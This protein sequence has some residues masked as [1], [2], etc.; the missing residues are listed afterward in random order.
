MESISETL[1]SLP[2][3]DKIKMIPGWD[4]FNKPVFGKASN[5]LPIILAVLFIIK[6]IVCFA[7]CSASGSRWL[8]EQ[9]NYS[10]I[11]IVFFFMLGIFVLFTAGV[12]TN[13]DIHTDFNN[14]LDKTRS[15]LLSG[16]TIVLAAS[17]VMECI[18]CGGK[19]IS[20]NDRYAGVCSW[21]HNGN[22]GMVFSVLFIGISIAVIWLTVER[23]NLD[24][25]FD[26]KNLDEPV[27]IGTIN[28]VE[29]K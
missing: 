29:K 9:L 2:P 15:K 3:A 21:F 18:L 6:T 20:A 27:P 8:C 25:L 17:I 24:N 22:S 1:S 14:G 19:F 12:R 13:Y 4:R 5:I 23:L 16:T 28:M 26:Y 11:R 7:S 10:N